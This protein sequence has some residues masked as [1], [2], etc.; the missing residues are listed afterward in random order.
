MQLHLR[1]L[2]TG[3]ATFLPLIGKYANRRTGGTES[4]R[5][6]YSVWMRH[7]VKAQT[8]GYSLAGTGRTI[9]ELGPG[10]SLGT[11]LAAMLSGFD[12]YFALD[13][14][15]HANAE[16]N[17]AIFQELL[18]LF[19]ER[20]PIP[21]EDEFP[22]VLPK[23]DDYS[24]PNRILTGGILKN[25]LDPQRIQAIEAAIQQ[26]GREIE[27]TIRIQYIAPWTDLSF[28]HPDS[29]D[30]V[31]SQATLEHVDDIA[32][33]Y[34]TLHSY[35]RPGGL[36]SHTI[37][38]KSHGLTRDWFGHWTIGDTSWYFVRGTRPY[39]INRLPHSA[40]LSA[41]EQAGLR[42]IMDVAERATAPQRAI[43]ARRFLALS[44]ADL[45]TCGTFIL[46]M[47][48]SPH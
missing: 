47:K 6:C 4:A 39:L 35:L 41:I 40:H 8:S 38:Y 13:V 16:R 18:H 2:A 1:S 20:A 26:A 36:M 22:L 9:A 30:F 45:A 43:L 48:P 7:L 42:V 14:K 3:A 37:D 10:D 15:V 23:L 32:V 5:Y 19:S 31:F 46:A 29:V 11:G 44:D 25:A 21:G 24:F 33:A 28:L 34:R 27:S 12:K 17:L